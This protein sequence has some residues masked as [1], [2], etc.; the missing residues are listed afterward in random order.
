MKN[1]NIYI[2]IVFLF[3][4]VVFIYHKQTHSIVGLG[5]Y[6]EIIDNLS[7]LQTG[8]NGLERPAD[9]DSYLRRFNS[10]VRPIK[11]KEPIQQT[12][13]YK[14][15]ID[16]RTRY[17]AES[18]LSRVVDILNQHTN[19]AYK[20]VDIEFIR[21]RREIKGQSSSLTIDFLIH[22]I[23]QYATRSYT[24]EAV[25]YPDENREG[26]Y[27]I[28]VNY[29]QPVGG[30]VPTIQPDNLIGVH[31]ADTD[32]VEK[33]INKQDLEYD[34][35]TNINGYYESSL[36]NSK[37]DYKYNDTP[38]EKSWIRNKDIALYPTG[39]T[40]QYGSIYDQLYKDPCR[41]EL[42]AWNTRGVQETTP[43]GVPGQCQ[44]INPSDYCWG[45]YPYINPTVT[46][47]PRN[48]DGMNELFDRSQGLT[49]R[50]MYR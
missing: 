37:L 33:P 35:L 29:I 49:S 38:I 2:I 47:L 5:E 4:T 48:N 50:A 15:N 25:C 22:Q 10:A 14:G 17:L 28:F 19:N 45:P 8:L 40:Q 32:F 6:K 34:R 42:F 7:S 39:T 18:V 30:H 27:R 43:P 41:R 16:I 36:E 24:L 9:L 46:A 31:G 44:I 21:E 26:G 11:L 13:Y 20:L 3:L 23:N 1:L 12:D